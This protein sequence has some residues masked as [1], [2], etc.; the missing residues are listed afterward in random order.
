MFPDCPK[1]IQLELSQNITT[2]V[3]DTLQLTSVISGVSIEDVEYYW[4]LIHEIN[5]PLYTFSV[6]V[7]IAFLII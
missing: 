2:V 1:H 6:M 4:W 3:I 5:S 7:D